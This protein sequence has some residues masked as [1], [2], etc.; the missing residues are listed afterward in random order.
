MRTSAIRVMASGTLLLSSFALISCGGPS[1][2][3]E[4]TPAFYWDAAK[5]TLGNKDYAKTLAHLEKITS[6]DNEFSA[7]A[8][9]WLLVM[10]SGMARGYTDLA[11]S[12]DAGSHTNKSN[13]TDFRRRTNTYRTEASRMTLEFAE[14]FDKFQQGKDDPVPLAFPFPTG[15]AAPV[16]PLTKAATGIMLSPAEIETAEKRAIERGVLL[17][18]SD[19]AGAPDD[20]AKARELLK[21][22]TP[23]VPRAAF[24]MTMAT[25]LFNESKLYGSRQI[26]DPEKVKILCNRALEALKTVPETKQTKELSSK[27]TKSLKTT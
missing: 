14:V 16:M 13:P 2:P 7:R 20:P 17:A 15:S 9:P 21:S 1:G 26:G 10:T 18:A 8:R 22:G 24:V 23:Q 6:T 19:A 4:G 12:F 25:T 27:I 3:Q 5:E 11:D